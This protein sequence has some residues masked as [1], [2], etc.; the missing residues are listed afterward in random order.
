MS[1]NEMIT[2]ITP[3]GDR[4]LPFY[5]CQKWMLR[6]T[7]LPDQWIVVDDGHDLRDD[8][9]VGSFTRVRRSPR[10]DGKF[11]L[12][13]NLRAALP[14]VSGSKILIWEDDEYYAPEYIETVA[15]RLD[16]YELVGIGHSRYYHI[17]SRGYHV[18]GNTEHAS[19]AQ[20]AFR[21]TFL[22]AFESQLQGSQF[23]DIRLWKTGADQHIYR[24]D[25]PLYVG[26]KGMPGRAGIGAG[27]NPRY[28]YRKAD[29]DGSVLQAW[30]RDAN[31]YEDIRSGALTESNIMEYE[32]TRWR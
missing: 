15:E 32:V 31:V 5:L 14:F 27:H 13:D 12:L 25:P 17:G 2:V 6:Q 18:H 10:E 21:V 1:A 30:C 16:R 29:G 8:L 19:L 26:I 28:C 7:R 20:T 23:L 9:R 22:P 11:T 4:P 24:D 3:T